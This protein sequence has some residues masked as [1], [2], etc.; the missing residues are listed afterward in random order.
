MLSTFKKL[1]PT[2]KTGHIARLIFKE[3]ILVQSDAHQ[4]NNGIYYS[5]TVI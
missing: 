3:H 5:V 4:G 1:L 2:N